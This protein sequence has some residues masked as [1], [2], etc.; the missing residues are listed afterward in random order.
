LSTDELVDV[1]LKINYA[2]G[3]DLDV[4]MHLIDVDDV[5]PPTIK[6]SDAKCC[7]SVNAYTIYMCTYFVLHCGSLIWRIVKG[8]RNKLPFLLFIVF[9]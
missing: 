1:V 3:F 4:D 8:S 9:S 6:L 7:R 5:A 2:Q